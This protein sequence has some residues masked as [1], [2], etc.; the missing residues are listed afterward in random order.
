MEAKDGSAGFDFEGVYDTVE[1][2]KRISYT[3]PDGRKVDIRFTD[4]GNATE[5]VEIF[6]AENMYP[7]DYQQAGW[8]AI[9]DN[10]KK[11]AEQKR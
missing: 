7:V 6:D 1:Q 5:V 2:H 4:H 3:M 10:F 9:L 11:Y 8:Q